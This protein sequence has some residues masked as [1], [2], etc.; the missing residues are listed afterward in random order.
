MNLCLLTAIRFNA[1]SISQVSALNMDASFGKRLLLLLLLLLSLLLCYVL[2][3]NLF[4][5]VF[6]TI[7]EYA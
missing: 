1:R 5:S 4:F 2:Q 6:R 7:C 3:Y